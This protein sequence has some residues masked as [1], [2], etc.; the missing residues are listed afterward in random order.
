MNDKVQ[1]AR[2]DDVPRP[3]EGLYLRDA[4]KKLAEISAV[5]FSLKCDLEPLTDDDI[6]HGAEPLSA[7]QIE[8]ELDRI[9][10]LVTMFALDELRATSDE[11][12]KAS[13]SIS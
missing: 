13:D 9:S 8:A 2:G 5:A 7:Q 4:L 11:W 6:A 3:M 10:D 12:L 1:N